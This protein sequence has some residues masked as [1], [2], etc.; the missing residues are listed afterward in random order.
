MKRVAIDLETHLIKPGQLFPKLVCV[1]ISD[2]IKHDLY[3]ASLG[4]IEII[5]LLRDPNVIIVGHNIA[6]DLGVIIAEAI[7]QGYDAHEIVSL[8]FQ[9]YADDRIVDTMIRAMLVDIA[10]GTFQEIEGQRRG[11]NYGLDT[12]AE[13]WLNQ[14]ITQKS[15]SR[16]QRIAGAGDGSW[17]LHFAALENVPLVDWPQDAYDYA[18]KDALI[19]WKVDEKISLWAIN[20]GIPAPGNIPDEFRQTR[21]AWVLRLMA[22]WG[23]SVDSEMV[24]LV[25]ENLEFEVQ[26]SYEVMEQY[27]LFKKDRCGGFKLTKK[28][29]RSKNLKKLKELI[30]EGYKAQGKEPPMTDGGK[31][32]IPQVKSGADEALESGHIACM[33]Y[34]RTCNAIKL[35]STY[36]PALE[37]GKN[38]TPVTSSPNVLVAS[39]RTS[40]QNPNW[41]NPPQGGSIRECVIPRRPQ[42]EEIEVPD[43]YSLKPGESWIT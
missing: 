29:Q 18:L 24:A 6:F 10:K 15:F 41:Q 8:V 14:Q 11:L 21:A 12:L 39:G 40:W 3:P 42:F 28:G 4:L 37:R 7:D 13:R 22:G 5:R 32:K 9:A 38:G 43:D 25:R 1:S 23:V 27:D 16:K 26:K 31:K 20:E 30:T 34:A 19:T 33:A 17:R 36:V 2:G 35:L